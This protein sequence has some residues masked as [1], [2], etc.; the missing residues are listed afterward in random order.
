MRQYELIDIDIY[1]LFLHPD[2]YILLLAITTPD[3][4]TYTYSY[5]TAMYIHIL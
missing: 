4:S 1:I 3:I 5:S 2:I